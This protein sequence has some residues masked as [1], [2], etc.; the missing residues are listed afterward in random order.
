PL[1]GLVLGG[2]ADILE[3]R[4]ETPSDAALG[5]D[6]VPE[7]RWVDTIT[8]VVLAPAPALLRVLGSQRSGQRSDERR[9]L[10]GVEPLA[11]AERAGSAVLGICRGAQLMNLAW[12]GSLLLDVQEF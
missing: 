5:A 10:L 6:S 7:R 3:A 12:V 8:S 1:H 11:G 2:G 9:D 4:G